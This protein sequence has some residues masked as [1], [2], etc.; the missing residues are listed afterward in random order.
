MWEKRQD[1]VKPRDGGQ[2]SVIVIR[3]M[4]VVS[5]FLAFFGVGRNDEQFT[6]AH[7]AFGDQMSS[8][9]FDFVTWPAQQRDFKTRMRIEMHMQR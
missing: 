6:I 9:M 7:A 2:Q 1:T 5:R 4:V 8:E 3:S